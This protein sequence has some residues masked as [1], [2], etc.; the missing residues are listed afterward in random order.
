MNID[1]GNKKRHPFWQS[2][3][4]V[5]AIW[6]LTTCENIGHFYSKDFFF[7]FWKLLRKCFLRF[8]GYFWKLLFFLYILIDFHYSTC[9][10]NNKGFSKKMLFMLFEFCYEYSESWIMQFLNFL[11]KNIW[12]YKCKVSDRTFTININNFY[13]ILRL[14]GDNR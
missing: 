3:C 12:W 1:I 7:K 2:R 6:C 8:F 10:N 13:F 11:N 9:K 14:D 5:R 4:L